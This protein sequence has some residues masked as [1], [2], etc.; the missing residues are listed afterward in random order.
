MWTSVAAI[1]SLLQ[2]QPNGVFPLSVRFLIGVV[3]C[4]LP[5]LDRVPLPLTAS[6]MDGTTAMPTHP[7]S[8]HTVHPECN[9]IRGTHGATTE[10]LLDRGREAADAIAAIAPA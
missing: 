6:G 3:E 1:H 9:S 4:F 7:S 8:A 5:P 10:V 2:D